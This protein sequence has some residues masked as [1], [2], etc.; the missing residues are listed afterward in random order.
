MV[1]IDLGE[2]ADNKIWS[3]R[4][5]RGCAQGATHKFFLRPDK[6]A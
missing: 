4:I 3:V 2:A 6:R 5:G 1:R